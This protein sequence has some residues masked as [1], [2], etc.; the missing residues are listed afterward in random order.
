MGIVMPRTARV[1]AR[2]GARA[3]RARA[4]QAH[5]D[6]ARAA[7]GVSA[8]SAGAAEPA[9]HDD[10]VDGRRAR[11]ALGRRRGRARGAAEPARRGEDGLTPLA[12]V[13]PA[14]RRH[15][16]V[17]GRVRGDGL[18]ASSRAARHC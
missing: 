4:R 2:A 13:K 7:R 12:D 1:R 3:A 17:R 15:V 5:R 10:A 9:G 8:R 18:R 14:A 6:P 11:R 16:G